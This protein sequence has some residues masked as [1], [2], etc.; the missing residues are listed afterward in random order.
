MKLPTS[1]DPIT[2]GIYGA[3]NPVRFYLAPAEFARWRGLP[4][5]PLVLGKIV[6]DQR[7]QLAREFPDVPV[8]VLEQ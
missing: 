8:E 1:L 6:R 5:T 3:K 7:E 4:V 2:P